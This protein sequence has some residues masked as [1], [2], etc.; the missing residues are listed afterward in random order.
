ME[1][2]EITYVNTNLN[3]VLE[4]ESQ[5]PR[6]T[7]K[8][9]VARKLRSHFVIAIADINETS[10]LTD[11]IR[12]CLLATHGQ[13]L[14]VGV[15]PRGFVA[16]TSPGHPQFPSSNEQNVLESVMQP[17]LINKKQE[18]HVDLLLVPTLPVWSKYIPWWMYSKQLRWVLQFLITAYVLFSVVWAFWQLH[19][20]FYLIQTV[21]DPLLI[22]LKTYMAPL[23]N[24]LDALLSVFTG[25]WYHFINPLY[26]LLGTLFTPL[27]GT[28][29]IFWIVLKP[30]F[31]LPIIRGVFWPFKTIWSIVANTRI[32]FS[33]FD[34]VRLRL[35][36]VRTVILNSIKTIWNGF[37]ALFKYSQ[38]KK[39]QH[40]AKKAVQ[41]GSKTY[42]PDLRKR[43]VSPAGVQSP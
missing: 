33:S 7:S 28:L 25:W 35:L 40:R 19:R 23:V 10:S 22:I 14:K 20:H 34:V 18:E 39:T 41:P 11:G 37:L 3:E 43:T 15:P 27:I 26:V 21:I 29:R 36:F 4:D 42:Q 38:I 5:L 12:A 8:K 17:S 13:S 6:A 30:L 31:N 1:V 2:D 32:D 16:D 9:A 24:F